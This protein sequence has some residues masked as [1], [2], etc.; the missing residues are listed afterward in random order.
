MTKRILAIIVSVTMMITFL[1]VFALAEAPVYCLAGYI[2]GGSYGIEEDWANPGEYQFDADGKL[3]VKFSEDSYVMMKTADCTEW[4]YF[5]SY[6]IAASGT[7]KNYTTGSSEMMFVPGNV[8]LTFTL[9][10]NGDDTFTLSYAEEKTITI[11]D[12]LPADFPTDDYDPWYN[13]ENDDVCLY[14]DEDSSK[15]VFDNTPF[16]DGVLISSVLSEAEKDPTWAD[17]TT[18]RLVYSTD[19]IVVQFNMT[20]DAGDELENIVVT[21]CVFTGVEGTYGPSECELYAINNGAP[22]GDKET[23]HGYITIDKETAEEDETVTVTVNPADGYK[24]KSLT[25]LSAISFA[26]PI[27]PTQDTQDTTK[28]TFSM[29][30][31]PVNVTAAF[32]EVSVSGGKTL[33]Y[34]FDFE[35][36]MT[37]EGWTNID[38]DGDGQD[39]VTGT[40]KYGV[41]GFGMDE[42]NCAISQSYDN[43]N[44]S[45]D[46]DNWLFSP[47]LVIPEGGATISWYEQSQDPD[48]PDSYTVYVGE[49]AVAEEY[50][51]LTSPNGMKKLYAGTA[52]YPWTQCSVELSAEEYGGKT[53]Y[54]A[55]RHKSFDCYFLDIDNF[56]AEEKSV[57][58]THT[59]TYA[60]DGGVLTATCEE[61]CDDG[62]DEN[63]LTLTLTAPENLAYDGNAK[64]FTFAAGEAD[65][66]T[67]AGLELPDI[68]YCI[69]QSGQ[70]EYLPLF[71]TL[72][73]ARNY[74]AQ[75]TVDGKT[76]QT[77]FAITKGTPYIKYQPEP[78]D[79]DY[80]EPLADSTLFGV[81]VQVS[82]T[83]STQVGGLFEWTEPDTVPGVADSNVTLYSVTFTPADE[84][85]FMAVTCQVTITV[86]HTHAPVLVNGQAATE[87]AAGFKDYYECACGAYYED[88]AGE[89]PIENLDVWKAEGGNGYIAPVTPIESTYTVT[90]YNGDP[91]EQGPDTYEEK[92]DGIHVYTFDLVFT[93]TTDKDLIMESACDEIYLEEMNVGNL[94]SNESKNSVIVHMTDSTIEGDFRTT[95]GE[96]E[97]YPCV[98]VDGNNAIKGDV[99]SD[100]TFTVYG[101]AGATLQVV[102]VT[103]EDYLILQNVR[104]ENVKEDYVFG[105]STTLTP[106]DASLPIT[107]TVKADV[108]FEDEETFIIN[109]GKPFAFGEDLEIG[110]P[111]VFDEN[112]KEFDPQPALDIF[113]YLVEDEYSFVQVDGVP[114]E[115]GDYCIAFFVS[116]DNPDYCGAGSYYFSIGHNIQKVTGKP[117]TTTEAGYKDYYVCEG[118][119]TYYEDEAGETPIDDL[120][121]WKAEGGAG[122]IAPIEPTET[123]VDL[124]IG[125]KEFIGVKGGVTLEV[126]SLDDL[127]DITVL[128]QNGVDVEGMSEDWS[129]STKFLDSEGRGVLE[130]QVFEEGDDYVTF[131]LQSHYADCPGANV[132]DF[133]IMMITAKLPAVE[134]LLGDANDDGTVDM[135]DVLTI[136][137]QLAGMAVSCNMQNADCNG[138]NAVDMKD[139]LMLRKYLAGLVETLGA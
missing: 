100:T 124:R 126:E 43:E 70:S 26:P 120:D 37:A 84:Q 39:W 123:T 4:Y 17:T 68:V 91:V 9:T 44:G 83:D 108:T 23:N 46:A 111:T 79:I 116:E 20:G 65:A 89:I 139:V 98:H 118:C 72:K 35:T 47:A 34:S 22:E 95:K 81:Y 92:A 115:E 97:M 64:A 45:F 52:A 7:L 73:F 99:V 25:V 129:M 128:A 5:D 10:D 56:A 2:N 96:G 80:G 86:T 103:T 105:E 107:I 48:Y 113:Y 53:V 8:D 127:Q 69:K 63:P 49:T 31:Y 11:A 1:P 109:N 62:F 41:Q 42:S 30:D 122:Y 55:F 19:D 130:V 136:R 133:Q 14:L 33:P 101:E 21:H 78:T 87:S 29:P 134:K 67:G 82:S 76:A 106:K 40:N 131:N 110:T 71:G 117:A 13:S 15:L 75:I 3:A 18:C 50:D 90:Y 104:L 121:A 74:M 57:S 132:E 16:S 36:D 102:S 125:G 112:G 38:A 6:V 85:N 54:I 114:T 12:I 51:E 135:K 24:L 119:D 66:W 60:A 27:F 94:F 138:D 88:A 59:F 32:E 28:Y 58:H 93:G 61:G 137:K 77:E